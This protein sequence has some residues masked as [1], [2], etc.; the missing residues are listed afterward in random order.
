MPWRNI[1][2]KHKLKERQEC[3]HDETRMDTQNHKNQM[4]MFVW[5]FWKHYKNHFR[6]KHL[7][8]VSVSGFLSMKRLLHIIHQ[9]FANSWWRYPL[10]NSALTVFTRFSPPGFLPISKMPCKDKYFLTFLRFNKLKNST[11]L[12]D[13][14]ENEFKERVHQWHHH[15][16]RGILWRW[17]LPIVTK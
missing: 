12:K 9:E 17:H 14:L 5:K 3:V 8:C 1:S 10:Q 11:F 6:G 4:Q 2:E 15:F 16:T 13:I 7:K